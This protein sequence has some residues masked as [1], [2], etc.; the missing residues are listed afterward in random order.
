MWRT[1][2]LTV[3]QTEGP[4]AVIFVST[5]E[6]GIGTT[7]S[8]EQRC[9]LASLP[10]VLCELVHDLTGSSTPVSGGA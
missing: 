8:F 9:E 1:L 5:A 10:S 4:E 6:E 7:S 2:N 3:V